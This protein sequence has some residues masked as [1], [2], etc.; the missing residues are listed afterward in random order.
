[1]TPMVQELRS[2]RKARGAFFTPPAIAAFLADWAVR[3]GD[4]VLEPSC[5]EAVFLEAAATAL[6]AQG[7]S[8]RANQLV[9]V[10]VHGPSVEAARERLA[11]KGIGAELV[12]SDY[13]A[14]DAS[15]GCDVVLGNPPYIRYQDFTG[16]L[17][18][19]ARR[20]AL[21][22]GVAL[23]AL[24]SSWAAFVVHSAAQ[25]APGGRMGMV[26]PAE[27]LTV[28]YAAPV[29]AFL[30]RH[31]K[32]VSLVGFD[33]R[34]FP[35]AQEEV[36]LLMADGWKPE[37]GEASPLRVGR[38]RDAAALLIEDLQFSQ[39]SP[40]APESRWNPAFGW[41]TA[42][43]A[44]SSSTDFVAL[45]EWGTIGIGAVTGRNTYFAIAQQDADKW[46]LPDESTVEL[47]PPGSRH[48]R[49]LEYTRSAWEAARDDGRR[50]LLF[51]PLGVPDP[52]SAAY[53]A[54]GEEDEVNRAYK[55]RVRSPWWFVPLTPV[56]DLFVTYMNAETVSFCANTARVQHLNSVH[57]MVLRASLR[58]IDPRAL[59]VAAVNSV[60]E[61]GAEMVGRAYGG[62]MLK[63]EPRE[64]QNLPL[65]S[66][67][68]VRRHEG[69][70]VGIADRSLAAAVPRA[71]IR[72][73]VDAA[74][75]E[76][77]GMADEDLQE[78]R[79]L[80]G[81]LRSRRAA[82]SGRVA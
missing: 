79:D 71:D 17:R 54:A 26:L 70:L 27:L 62:G 43:A 39:W 69:L 1:M 77:L 46:S 34:V 29:R 3:P 64:A 55:C 81:L 40:P 30:L 59:A 5:G 60:T 63:V 58:D 6:T 20:A 14:W 75:E 73:Q 74:I 11:A 24:A 78:M 23:S 32:A 18:A 8:P 22:V 66:P 15:A 21:S 61:L 52:A 36:V 49:G 50:C 33:S 28:N 7:R 38:V 53:I 12:T 2:E 72:A 42:Y 41:S 9:G 35:D 67:E 31:F 47:S 82:R 45:R 51:R 25:L 4:R 57:G 56:A 80:C 37:G 19:Q 76:D 48:L 16:D 65:P 13:F 68:W 44:W 10:D